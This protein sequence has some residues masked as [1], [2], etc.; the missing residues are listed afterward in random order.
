MYSAAKWIVAMPFILLALMFV[1]LVICGERSRRRAAAAQDAAEQAERE[2]IAAKENAK[3]RAEEQRAAAEQE[4][5]RRR[6]EREAAQ[7]QR[8]A[9][10]V[11]KARELAE[12][13]ERALNAEKELRALKAQPE[14]P[15]NHS[16]PAV[17]DAEQSAT[18]I[19][20]LTLDEFAERLAAFDAPKPFAGHVV[21]FTGTL[22][23]DAGNHITRKDAIALVR[24]LGGK[25]YENM[26]AGTTL[27]VVGDRP[28]TDKLDKADQW[29]SQVT[30]ITPHRFFEMTRRAA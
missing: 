12:L 16:A 22:R 21:A 9:A 13:K 20:T 4:R 24:S 10:K 23:D 27:L 26:P 6:A 29:I 18:D 8:H 11:A 3:R 2:R 17:S 30:K 25:A 14:T 28:G 19:V 5:Q 15:A 7:A 1:V